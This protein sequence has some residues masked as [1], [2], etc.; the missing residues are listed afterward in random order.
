MHSPFSDRV[1]HWAKLVVSRRGAASGIVA[2]QGAQGSRHHWLL[3]LATLGFTGLTML[4]VYL[5]SLIALARIDALPPPPIVNSVCADIKLQFFRDHPPEQPTL[6]VVGSSVAWRDIDSAQFVRTNPRARPLN[7]GFCAA[8]MHQTH[9]VSNYFIERYP[10]INTVVAVLEPHDFRACTRTTTQLFSP[11]DA[12]D[13][14]YHRTWLYG[15][16]LRYFDLWALQRNA[17]HLHAVRTGRD[18]SDPMT[19]T[20]YADG[21][22]EGATGG[23]DLVYGKF[24]GFDWSCFTRLHQMAEE[25][26]VQKR[27]FFVTTAPLNPAWRSRFDVHGSVRKAF[28]AGIRNALSGTGAEFWDS[29]ESFQAEPGMFADAVHLLWPAAQKFSDALAAA[30]EQDAAER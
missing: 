20:P 23:G 25:L 11:S 7:A 19:F 16:Y 15:L 1:Y 2:G 14:I 28:V 29:A 24:E 8:Q 9:F 10:S 12:D 5:G 22:L 26:K 6:L 17:R 3:Y 13:Y 27:H 4:A 18:L 21:P 30:L